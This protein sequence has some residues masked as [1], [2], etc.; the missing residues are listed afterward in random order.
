MK[1]LTFIVCSLI[2]YCIVSGQNAIVFKKHSSSKVRVI[3]QASLNILQVT[4]FSKSGEKGQLRIVD[5]LMFMGKDS[6]TAVEIKKV[7]K[8]SVFPFVVGAVFFVVG[9]GLALGTSTI[10]FLALLPATDWMFVFFNPVTLGSVG[11]MGVGALIA[12]P[13]K[14]YHS[15]RWSISLEPIS[16]TQ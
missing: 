14:H 15:K 2:T 11:L 12:L 4:V 3:D 7:S 16:S 9:G 5:S 1:I 13:K 8:K 10:A 6:I